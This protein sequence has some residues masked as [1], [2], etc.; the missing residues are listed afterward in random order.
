MEQSQ[1]GLS[2]GDAAYIAY[3]NK[4][5]VWR[6]ESEGKGAQCPSRREPGKFKDAGKSTEPCIEAARY[7]DLQLRVGAL[8]RTRRTQRY[9]HTDIIAG[10][11][12][13]WAQHPG[14]SVQGCPENADIG[15][16]IA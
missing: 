11:R 14:D 15:T 12:H 13:F 9:W 16:N 4:S 6:V 1:R 8:G 5:K 10:K 2:R 3:S 7:T